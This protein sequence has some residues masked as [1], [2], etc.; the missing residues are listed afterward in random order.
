V[1]IE[2]SNENQEELSKELKLR[3]FKISELKRLNEE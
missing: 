2:E 1:E 3:E